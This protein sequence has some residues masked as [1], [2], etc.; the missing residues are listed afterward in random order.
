MDFREV[1]EPDIELNLI[2]NGREEET[3]GDLWWAIRVGDCSLDADLDFLDLGLLCFSHGSTES[4]SEP[5]PLTIPFRSGIMFSMANV[6][7][8]AKRV[9][10][11][12][13][14]VEGN[15]LR[16][17]ARMAG[18]SR[19]TVNKLLLELGA[20]CD[21][22]Q[23][24]QPVD[25]PTSRIECDEIW[26]F[27]GMKAKSV[28][29]ERRGE[30]GVGDVWTFVALDA[31][32]KLCISWLVGPRDTPTATEFMQDVAGRVRR[33]VQLTTDGHKMYLEAVEDAFGAGIDYAMLHKI[34]GS[35]PETET[36][37]S[38]AV[39]NGTKRIAIQGDPDAAFVST[40]YVERSN[41]DMRMRMRRFTRFSKALQQHYASLALHF[42][43][44]NWCRIHGTLRV[45]P[46]MAAGLATRPWEIEN[47]LALMEPVQHS[48]GRPRLAK[49][50]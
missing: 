18:V 11:V 50:I 32:T 34:Y 30:F 8:T 9:Q 2:S 37:Y 15:S 41:L 12:H 35:V 23:A 25:L 39:C 20:A 14:L 40:S 10:I 44:I 45:T 26:S 17:T 31:E 36:R 5:T 3:A 19:N 22:F 28:P 33:R 6:L 46:A 48:G 27:V 43:Y 38:P 47:L 29:E 24:E 1:S 16:A 13:A 21:K 49:T 4:I 7:S 42:A